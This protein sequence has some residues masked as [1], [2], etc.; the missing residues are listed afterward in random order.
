MAKFKPELYFNF[1]NVSPSSLQQDMLVT[2]KY[3]S[4]NGVHDKVPLVYVL[5]KRIDKFYGIN[6]H[7]DMAEL[8]SMI[9]SKNEQLLE[10]YE[11]EFYRKNREKEQELRKNREEF[12]L[13]MIDPKDKIE[14]DR[15]LNKKELETYLLQ[16]SGNSSA[17][18]CYLFKR[19]NSVSKLVFKV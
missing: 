10:F 17:L 1:S 14:F 5:E 13:S 11:K 12:D 19:M 16:N 4:P 2:F 6:L 18:R 15:R 7:Y 8:N 3:Q 9:E